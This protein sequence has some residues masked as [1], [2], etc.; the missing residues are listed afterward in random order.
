MRRIN[1]RF[2]AAIIL[3][4]FVIFTLHSLYT[5]TSVFADAKF[6]YSYTRSVVFDHNLFLGNEFFRLKLLRQLPNNQFIPSFY[7]PGVSIFW[8]PLFYFTFGLMNLIQ[9]FFKGI[10]VSGYEAIFEYS[11]S[12]TSIF[13]TVFGL[14]LIYRLLC[15]RFSQK[16][17]LFTVLLIFFASNLFFYTAVEPISSHAASF[18]VSAL[19]IYYLLDHKKDKNYYLTLSV[20]GGAAGLIRTQDLLLLT[21]PILEILIHGKQNISKAIKAFLQIILGSFLGFLPQIILWKYFYNTYFFS[22]Y[23]NVGFNFLHPQILHVLI[24][25]QNGLFLKTPITAVALIGLIIKVYGYYK[26]KFLNG[27]KK[28][29]YHNPN[30]SLYLIALFYFFIQL[31]LVSSWNV[32]SQG[33][34]YSIRMIV[35]TYPLLVFGLAEV[36]KYAFKKFNS[37]VIFL[38]SLLFITFNFF[39]ILDY[40]I[41]Y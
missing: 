11:C 30:D 28:T 36:V 8:L 16:V 25:N 5:K 18:F 33:G 39:S 38:I 2:F 37:R 24:N 13:L 35:T 27:Y 3:I 41:K 1:Q 32:Y 40:L 31:Y 4:S 15:K 12:V 34:S 29:R 14:Y 10:T 20:I 23:L 26:N 17:G 19:F 6:Y 22:P 21:L 7:P 9:I